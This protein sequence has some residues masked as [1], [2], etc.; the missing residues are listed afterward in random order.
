MYDCP[1]G[2]LKKE[3]A[4]EMYRMIL[5]DKNALVFV[6]HIFRIFDK[7]NNEEI[8]FKE[9]WK[10]IIFKILIVNCFSYRNS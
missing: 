8:D 2:K 5:P 9:S 1:S 4:I 6:D 10:Y 3:K 7:D